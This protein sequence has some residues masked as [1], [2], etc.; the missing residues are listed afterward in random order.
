MVASAVTGRHRHPRPAAPAQT[1]SRARQVAA[2]AR[3]FTRP[4]R[5]DS[6]ESGW[7]AHWAC[8]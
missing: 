7:P 2:W 5:V 1:R 4:R 3:E 6:S 8:W